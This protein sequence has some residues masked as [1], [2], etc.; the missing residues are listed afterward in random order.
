[1]IPS[2]FQWNARRK[3]DSRMVGKSALTLTLSPRRGDD[4][5][6]SLFLRRMIPPTPSLESSEK[7]GAILPLLGGGGRGE[8]GHPHR[9]L[10]TANSIHSTKTNM[11]KLLV[12]I[13]LLDLLA[14]SRAGLLNQL[15]SL[16]AT[17]PAALSTTNVAA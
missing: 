1:M 16:A 17:K 14:T 9:K 4:R 13:T 6:P 7:R 11:K 12:I 15:E 10:Q 2:Y 3:S 8:G 5:S